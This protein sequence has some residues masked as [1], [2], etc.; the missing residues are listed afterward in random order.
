MRGIKEEGEIDE[1]ERAPAENCTLRD[2]I[3]LSDDAI[4]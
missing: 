2:V 4:M 1:R 3:V